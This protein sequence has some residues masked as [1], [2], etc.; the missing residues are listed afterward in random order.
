M[1]EK[2]ILDPCFLSLLFSVV[3]VLGRVGDRIGT[4]IK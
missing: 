1:L 3:G 2:C 4:L